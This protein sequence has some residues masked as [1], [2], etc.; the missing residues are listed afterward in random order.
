MVSSRPFS[1]SMRP[2]TFP[3]PQQLATVRIQQAFVIGK[4]CTGVAGCE[5]D[6]YPWVKADLTQDGQAVTGSV[7]IPTEGDDW[8][9]TVQGSVSADGTLS[10]TSDNQ[11]PAGQGV[12]WRL[13]S[14]ETRMDRP[15]IMTGTVALHISSDNLPGTLIVEV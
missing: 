11:V 8:I 13:A 9:F 10:L 5:A 6:Y 15:G 7:S 12:S 4:S 14:W 2:G 3:C 1:R